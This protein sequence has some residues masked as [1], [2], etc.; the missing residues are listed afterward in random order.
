[1]FDRLHVILANVDIG[2]N[3]ENSDPLSGEDAV[4]SLKSGVTLE[5]DS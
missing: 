3:G 1:M 4:I 2:L 5:R